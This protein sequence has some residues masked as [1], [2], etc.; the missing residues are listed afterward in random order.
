MITHFQKTRTL[1]FL[2]PFFISSPLPFAFFLSL[3]P[4]PSFLHFP[5]LILFVSLF[6]LSSS[7]SSLSSSFAHSSFYL[8]LFFFHQFKS[9]RDIA[10]QRLCPNSFGGQVAVEAG[11]TQPPFACTRIAFLWITPFAGSNHFAI[12]CSCPDRTQA[13]PSSFFQI[14]VLL[15]AL[16]AWL[17]M[18][19]RGEGEILHQIL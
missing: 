16:E 18:C 12:S 6:F 17:F 2:S 13:H 1:P 11:M 14:D 8:H 5:F 4:A 15:L 7:S 19:G 9:H 3:S 10:S